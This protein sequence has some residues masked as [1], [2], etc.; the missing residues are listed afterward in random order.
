[1][2][3]QI[4]QKLTRNLRPRMNQK[5]QNSQRWKHRRRKKVRKRRKEKQRKRKVLTR[6]G[7]RGRPSSL[8]KTERKMLWRPRTMRMSRKMM[9][10]RKENRGR[11]SPNL[12]LTWRRRN[13]QKRNPKNLRKLKRLQEL[14]RRRVKQG[15]PNPT[16][17]NQAMILR[18]LKRLIWK[19]N[20]A[21]HQKRR[22]KRRSLQSQKY[23]SRLLPRLRVRG[24][25]RQRRQRRKGKLMLLR[26]RSATLK[27]TKQMLK[28]RL[29]R[30]TLPF[31]Q[32]EMRNSRTPTQW[33]S[34]KAG[35][36][37]GRAHRRTRMPL[38]AQLKV[39]K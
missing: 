13:R 8:V 36:L 23:R 33:K 28:S 16:K 32:K 34:P 6:F 7:R 27:T 38:R 31:H 4:T 11:M 20:G 30:M 37:K 22:T 14:R 25:R 3:I 18:N 5:K 12:I 9:R 24:Q 17:R 26:R 15:Q 39:R 29:L 35:R 2:L 1:M 21:S 19:R 10:M